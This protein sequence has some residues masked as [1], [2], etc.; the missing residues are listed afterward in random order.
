[1]LDN[2]LVN[3][4]KICYRFYSNKHEIENKLYS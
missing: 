3:A 1:M 4:D 2:Y